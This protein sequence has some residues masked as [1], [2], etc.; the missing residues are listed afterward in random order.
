MEYKWKRHS[1][2]SGTIRHGL[3]RELTAIAI[4]IFALTPA[5]CLGGRNNLAPII[6][7]C[8][9]LSA[10]IPIII[11]M[12]IDFKEKQPLNVYSIFV[13]ILLFAL[14][15]FSAFFLYDFLQD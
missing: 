8:F 11:D 12:K 1:S 15:V 4:T 9:F 7:A 13:I 6:S 2:I 5:L 10:V 14:S 3:F